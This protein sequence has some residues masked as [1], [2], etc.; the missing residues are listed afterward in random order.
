MLFLG[1]TYRRH[2]SKQKLK[3]GLWSGKGIEWQ[4]DFSVSKGSGLLAKVLVFTDAAAA[5]R[6]AK[7]FRYGNDVEGAGGFVLECAL[8]RPDEKRG[9]ML[10]EVDPLYFAVMGIVKNSLCLDTVAHE[11]VHLA[12][13]YARRTQFNHQWPG[14]DVAAEEHIAYPVGGLTADIW[15]ALV[16]DCVIGPHLR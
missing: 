15:A 16:R 3:K 8:G 11:S 2:L 1:G 7:R 14:A 9:G 5:G 10:W 6:W 12:F 13:A 4:A